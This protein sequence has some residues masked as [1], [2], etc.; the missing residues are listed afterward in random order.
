MG[1][2]S[3]KPQPPPG[4]FELDAVKPS[5]DNKHLELRNQAGDWIATMRQCLENMLVAIA[6]DEPRA[7][8]GVWKALCERAGS[9]EPFD[10]VIHPILE[11]LPEQDSDTK[12]AGYKLSDQ[13]SNT[14]RVAV[15]AAPPDLGARLASTL[16]QY[17]LLEKRDKDAIR[18]F[19]KQGRQPPTYN[20]MLTAAAKRELLEAVGAGDLAKLQ[21]LRRTVCT[22]EELLQA[23]IDHYRFLEQI[24]EYGMSQR[25]SDEIKA[26]IKFPDRIYGEN[27]AVSAAQEVLDA[28]CLGSH[29][30]DITGGIVRVRD[31]RGSG[32]ADEPPTKKARA[33][34]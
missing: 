32:V 3:S 22:P 5:E 9:A 7:V 1:K 28:G 26:A 4:Y 25:M 20:M 23:D 11:R 15:I 14:M 12:L 19:A 27:K 16:H 10:A 24:G 17:M 34:P 13:I 21:W 2:R 30:F 31:T 33:A 18:D 6:S 29:C 8:R